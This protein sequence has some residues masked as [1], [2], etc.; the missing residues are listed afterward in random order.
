MDLFGPAGSHL[1]NLPSAFS[2]LSPSTS[3]SYAVQ[4]AD[5]IGV[6]VGQEGPAGNERSGG[7]GRSGSKRGLAHDP[8]RHDPMGVFGGGWV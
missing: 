4:A 7:S 6:R 3:F 8:S 5:L 1:N 2:G